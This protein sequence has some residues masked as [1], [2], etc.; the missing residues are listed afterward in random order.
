MKYM[1]LINNDPAAMGRL[2]QE[3]QDRIMADVGELMEELTAN[4]ELISGAAL[5]PISETRTV[6]VK[7]G[8][9][10]TTDGPFVEVKEHLA[11]YVMVDVTGIERA[12]EIAS[13]WPDARTGA[14][15]VRPVLDTID[16]A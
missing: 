12:I 14:M 16:P 5:E 1:L 15:E 6:Q 8:E 13:R 2:P 3:D 10:V 4:R 9:V 11:G 7:D